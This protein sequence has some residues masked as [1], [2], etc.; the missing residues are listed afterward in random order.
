[1]YIVKAPS[2]TRTRMCRS[3]LLIFFRRPRFTR[4][5]KPVAHPRLR[6]D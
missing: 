3:V 5:L 2:R 6:Q 4:R 1:M